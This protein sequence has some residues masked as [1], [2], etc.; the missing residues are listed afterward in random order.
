MAWVNVIKAFFVWLGSFG[1]LL[2]T[3]VAL[4]IP[5]F[6]YRW[7]N[8]DFPR[9][10]AIVADKGLILISLVGT[11]LAHILTLGLL[12]FFV[13]ENGRKPFAAT[14]GFKWPK[15]IP[16]AI[17][18]L[19]CS[20]LAIV[21]LA[22][23]WAITQVVGGEKTQLDLIVESS[24]AARLV[25]ALAAFATAPLIEELVYRGVLYGALERAA[26]VGVSVAIVSL[27]FAAIHVFQYSNNVGVIVVITVLSITLTL[28]R[29]YTGSVI[30]P[31]IIHLVF[32]GIQSL[33]L[34]ITPFLDKSILHREEVTPTAPG[35]EF[36]FQLCEKISVYLCRMT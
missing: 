28:A 9:P 20:L 30:P 29:A 26:G 23:G 11:I 5:Y 8:R 13:T 1:L 33:V 3:P 15:T 2:L 18:I 24:M 10:E 17:V 25:T 7:V 31:F 21:L 34:V 35:F 36:A 22:I 6:V 4:A 12:W 19:V 27:L 16:P 32:N 14:I